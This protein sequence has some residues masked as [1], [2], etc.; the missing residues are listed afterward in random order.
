[1]KTVTTLLLAFVLCLSASVASAQ[2]VR[3]MGVQFVPTPF[4]SGVYPYAYYGYGY[5]PY[6]YGYNGYIR[7]HNLGPITHTY[8]VTPWTGPFNSTTRNLGGGIQHTYFTYGW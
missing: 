8:G 6:G 1:M 5:N 2:W 3:G 7:Q 4:H